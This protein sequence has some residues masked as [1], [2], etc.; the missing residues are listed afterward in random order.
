MTKQTQFVNYSGWLMMMMMVVVVW[1]SVV[2]D[3]GWSGYVTLHIMFRFYFLSFL[4][5]EFPI[6][7]KWWQCDDDYNWCLFSWW[8]GGNVINTSFMFDYIQYGV[9]FF[10]FNLALIKSLPTMVLLSVYAWHGQT[11]LAFLFHRYEQI[12]IN[13]Y[14]L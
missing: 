8:T 6:F 12:Y 3:G 4:I 7:L 14:L 11:H 5:D 13:V 10:S 1:F 2:G 9:F